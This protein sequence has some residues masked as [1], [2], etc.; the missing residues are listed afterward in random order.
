MQYI[1]T[2]V[3]SKGESKGGKIEA[4]S[5][6]E[7]AEQLKAKGYLITSIKALEDKKQNKS[8]LD[9]SHFFSSVSL[10]DK[11]MFA[12][13]LSVMLGSG[14]ILSRSLQNLIKQTKNKT[15][16]DI[17]QKIYDDVEGGRSLSESLA[18]Y[19]NVFNNLFV[20]MVRVGEIGG[21]LEETLGI[22]ALYLE[23]D[24]KLKKKIKGAML[25]PMV[26]IVAMIGITVLMLTF[27][28]PKILSVF[29][30]MDVELP[31]TTQFIVHMSDLLRSHSV[32]VT[33]GGI[34]LVIGGKLFLKTKTGKKWLSFA[35]INIPAVSN[36]TKKS[37]S[38]R[39]TRTYS[40]LLHS[41]VSAIDSLQITAETLDN[42]YY[43]EALLYAV[44]EIQKGVSLSDI[45]KRYPKIFPVLVSQ[46]I[47]VG[48]ET[49]KTDAML[50]K[51]AEFYEEEVDQITKNISSIIEPVLILLIGGMVGFF[52]IAM[53][54]PMYSVMEN[55]K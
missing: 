41:G 37:N 48:E 21:N 29:E 7:V 34:I 40:S 51:L 32:L 12:K 22:V 36:M 44:K 28:L 10:K 1:Y 33:I 26:V 14:L 31:K 16:R 55:I 45:I 46:I 20:S 5:E 52:A 54:Q 49:G 24:Y 30:G 42:Y 6:K 43:R 4:E 39:F 18:A 17:L 25:Y 47:E 2:A 53:L 50:L 38:A 27:I 23:K 19:P 13:N 3:N 35:L 9:L 11:M 8:S 15:F